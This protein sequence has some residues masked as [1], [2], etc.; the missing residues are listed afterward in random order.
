MLFGCTNT[1]QQA[2]T[3][4]YHGKVITVDQDFSI[5][6]AVAVKDG[7][8]LA[9]GKDRVILKLAGRNTRRIDLHGRTVIPGINEGHVHPVSAAR[10]EYLQP[11][12]DIRSIRELLGWIHHQASV[13]SPGKWIVHPK[14]FATRMLEMRMPT[15]LELDSVA[16][17]HPV[18]LDGS[19]GGMVNSSALQISELS[20]KTTHPGVLKNKETNEPTG[21]IR[22]S[23]FG[24]LKLPPDDGMS[25]Q[26][27]LE[28]LRELLQLYNQ[29]GITSICAGSGGP[30][31]LQLFRS[32]RE[33]GQLSV[34]VFQ[35]MYIPFDP[36][37]SLDEMR[38]SLSSFQYTTG[39][40]DEWVKVGALK[41]LVDGGILTGT[42]YLREPYGKNAADVYG[43]SDPDYRGY[44]NLTKEELTRI[45]TAAN[46]FGWK[47]TSHITGGGGVDEFLAAMEEVNR[48][49]P[50]NQK[51]F[52]IIHG[53]F[54]TENAIHK[55]AS[56]GIY[57]DMQPA[58]Y[59]KDADLLFQVLGEKRM[60]TFHPYKSL[61]EAGVLVNGGSDHMVKFDS[62]TSINPYNPFLAIWSLVTRK[63]ERE[64]IYS[65]T[66]SISREQALKMYT[67]NNAYA[68]FE[69]GIKGSIETGKLA[70]LAV[71][72]QDI[73]TC[74]EEKI[75]DIQV[76][77]TMIDGETVYRNPLILNDQ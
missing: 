26:Q 5:Q 21:F 24:L 34:R 54:F 13:K 59:Y 57:A 14:F 35:N 9:V 42:A 44:L 64:Q 45:G 67:I 18:F 33:A 70:D 75:K 29:V 46:E 37:I 32:L 30:G 47:F 49:S 72:S 17:N 65:A 56:M 52:S 60:N 36:H 1:A 76:L 38:K 28:V 15:K 16:P 20:A 74:P 23:A 19:Y 77:L 66:E 22:R 3:V 11:V 39:D 73:L 71:L 25:Q 7:K 31:D 48:L 50:I 55:M 43:I 40:G 8:I 41:T 62:Y 63:T 61:I 51:R 69:E 6:E 27:Q 4:L 68:S 12:P 58:W 10:K 53:N 2:D